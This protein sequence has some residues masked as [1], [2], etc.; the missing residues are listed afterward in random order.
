MFLRSKGLFLEPVE[1]VLGNALGNPLWEK[2]E[3][4]DWVFSCG[5]GIPKLELDEFHESRTFC[6]GPCPVVG[7]ALITGA[8]PGGGTGCLTVGDFFLGAFFGFTVFFGGEVSLVVFFSVFFS[9]SFRSMSSPASS[10]PV[11]ISGASSRRAC[12]AFLIAFA[13]PMSNHKPVSE[14]S[15]RNRPGGSMVLIC[16]IIRAAMCAFSSFFVLFDRYSFLCS[17]TISRN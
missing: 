8:A 15:F 12:P 3:F 4:V 1:A 17:T 2:P 14:S 5:N 13:S 11:R 9:M 7:I 6:C 16:W 10:S